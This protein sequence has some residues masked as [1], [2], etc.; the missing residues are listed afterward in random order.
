MKYNCKQCDFKWEGT[1]HTF[2]KVREHEKIH[3]ENN[4]L[5]RSKNATRSIRCRVCNTTK[6]V[7][8][9][10]N[11]NNVKWECKTCGNLLDEQGNITT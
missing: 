9:D 11:A 2:D 10:Q 1:S 7:K 5:K 4:K 6:N 3:H 8:T